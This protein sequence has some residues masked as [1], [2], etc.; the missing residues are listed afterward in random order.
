M[1]KYV[2]LWTPR[3]IFFKASDSGI[4][5]MASN[6]I[7]GSYSHWH[8]VSY[9]HGLTLIGHSFGCCWKKS[10]AC[11][12]ECN[13]YIIKSISETSSDSS[14]KVDF[15]SSFFAKIFLLF[16]KVKNVYKCLLLNF[17]Q[18]NWMF[19]LFVA[20]NICFW[21]TGVQRW[22]WY[23]NYQSWECSS[24]PGGIITVVAAGSCTPNNSKMGACRFIWADWHTYSLW[25]RWSRL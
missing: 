7:L 1:Q 6:L 20:S 23:F 12:D 11:F 24:P 2:L 19:Y 4:S 25:Q 3:I 18:R 10:E 21:I 17:S 14:N 22:S 15:Y 16:L 13:L 9:K 8:I 5:M